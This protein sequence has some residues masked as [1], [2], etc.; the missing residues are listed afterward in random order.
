[1]SWSCGTKLK[2]SQS[3]P[4]HCRHCVAGMPLGSSEVLHHLLGCWPFWE[5]CQTFYRLL[6]SPAIQSSDSGMIFHDFPGGHGLIGNWCAKNFIWVC[7]KIG[8][9]LNEIAIIHKDHDQQ[10]HW[11]NRG[12]HH[13]QTHP[14]CESCRSIKVSCGARSRGFKPS[15]WGLLGGAKNS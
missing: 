5:A 3:H 8:Y 6:G 1:M 4:R 10:N 15:G 9:I 12:T 14:S 13:F 7:L 2:A 11:V